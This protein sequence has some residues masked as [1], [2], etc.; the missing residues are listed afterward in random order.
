VEH[1]M[2]SGIAAVLPPG[3]VGAEMHG[4]EDTAEAELFESERA[5]VAGSVPGRRREFAGGRACAR[6]ALQRLGAPAVAIPA[7]PDGAPRWP[8][9]IVGS[10]THKAGYRA[11]AVARTERLAGLGIDAEL[12]APLPAGVLETIASPDELEA[13]ERLLAERPGVAWDRLLFSAK[14]AAVKAA[15]P[16]RGAAGLRG[17][18]VELDAEAGTFKA[19]LPAGGAAGA[20]GLTALTG[21]WAAASGLILS[22]ASVPAPARQEPGPTAS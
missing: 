13:V 21:A 6:E 15:R 18:G 7:D 19:T 1:L 4:G 5:L 20:G 2:S 10:I 17:V 9:G 8:P 11:A 12:D 22:A 16:L 3:A 14:E